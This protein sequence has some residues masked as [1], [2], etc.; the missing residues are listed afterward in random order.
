[1]GG[2]PARVCEDYSMW[3]GLVLERAGRV[4]PIPA[5]SRPMAKLSRAR[6]QES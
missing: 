2:V 4:W 3:N 1:M 5:P 6:P